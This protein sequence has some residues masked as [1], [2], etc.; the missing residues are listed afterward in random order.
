[1]ASGSRLRTIGRVGSVAATTAP[2]VRRIASD[3]DLRD[4]VVNAVRAVGDL[5]NQ[6]RSD[7]PLRNDLRS[8]LDSAQS[9]RDHVVEDVKPRHFLRN[10]LIGAGLVTAAL[11]VGIALAWQRTRQ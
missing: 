11:G 1:M 10:L 3:E 6:I 2:Y 7:E 9:A 5:V 4:D 8:L